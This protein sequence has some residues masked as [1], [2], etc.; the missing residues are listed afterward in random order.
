M[1]N[2]ATEGQQTANT[3]GSDF[4]ALQ[5]IAKQLLSRANIGSL[6]RVV[7]VSNAGGV[8]PVGTVDVL[9]LVNQTDG[10]G[11]V[12]PHVTVYGL[13]YFRLQGGANAII[14][15]PQ[16]GDIGMA[17]ISH[18]DISSV[19]ATKDQANPGSA[20]RNSWSDGVYFG[21][22]LN[23]IPEQYVRFSTDGIDVV[24]PIKIKLMAPEVQILTD[25]LDMQASESA[26]MNSP[27]NN[28]AGGGTVVDARNFLGHEHD[29]TK[30][31]LP[32]EH[33]GPVV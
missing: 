2:P 21:G 5:F 17:V 1:S 29:E 26:T 33:S 32:G 15:D 22:L 13:P 3:G 16:I 20:R 19:K 7:A 28:I 25:V 31:G 4:N 8:S 12:V 14:L 18:N 30:P 6:V 23:G 24:S 10:G 9:P 27:E 11:N